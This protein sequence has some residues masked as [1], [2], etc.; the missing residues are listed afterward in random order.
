LPRPSDAKPVRRWFGQRLA[1]CGKRASIACVHVNATGQLSGW[2][3]FLL[4][5]S[6]FRSAVDVVLGL[7]TLHVFLQVGLVGIIRYA[8]ERRLDLLD[9]FVKIA[10]PAVDA[11]QADM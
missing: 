9:C 3:I 6:R 7:Q 11:G 5:S 1:G 8:R 4:T 10:L 2:P